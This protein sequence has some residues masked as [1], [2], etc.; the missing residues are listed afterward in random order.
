MSLEI[1]DYEVHEAENGDR[2]LP[3]IRSVK[4]ALVLL[5]VMMPGSLDGFQVCE[6][7]K[8][9]PETRRTKV[10]MLTARGQVDD[11]RRSVQAGADGFMVKPFSPLELLQTVEQFLR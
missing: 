8:G 11:R 4:P 1:D 7:L 10:L 3:L 6:K 5:D 2:A 9:D